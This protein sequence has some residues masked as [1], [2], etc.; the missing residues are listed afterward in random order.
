MDSEELV[1]PGVCIKTHFNRR[2][3]YSLRKYLPFSVKETG[4][5]SF[6]LDIQRLS[7]QFSMYALIARVRNN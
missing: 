1:P 4:F 3:Q 7:L 6:L 2:Q 5:Y